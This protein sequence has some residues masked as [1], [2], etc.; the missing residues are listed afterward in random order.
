MSNTLS[1][2]MFVA[3]ALAALTAPL[4]LAPA[5]LAQQPAQAPARSGEARGANRAENAGAF[6]DARIAG[7]KAG[8]RLTPEQDK[9]WPAFEQAYRDL[10][11][12]RIERRGQIQGQ[13]Q[14]S[15]QGQG[16]AA[17][18]EDRAA[19][20]VARLARRADL[21]ST[22]GAALKRLADAAAPLYQSL[23]EAQKQR[24]IVLSRLT[25]HHGYGMM[26]PGRMGGGMMDQGMMGGRM[27]PGFVGPDRWNQRER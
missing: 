17:A 4:A 9:S 24:F 25:G 15:V 27:G 6:L 20:P 22:H 3:A 21:L 19:D 18:G 1:K 14:G 13:I 7:L 8:L 12:L 5:A 11:K 16:P 26:G 2:K 23:D 10:A